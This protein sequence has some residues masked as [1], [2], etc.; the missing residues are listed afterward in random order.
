MILRVALFLLMALGLGGFGTIAWM[1]MQPPPPPP[2]SA[3]ADA[4]P[5]PPARANVRAA[6]RPLRAGTLVRP[7]DFAPR[8]MLASEVPPD[9]VPDT[10]TVRAQLGGGMLRR[11]LG[12]GDPFLRP[13]VMRPGDRGFLAAVLG[14]GTR[15][16]S[17]TVDGTLSAGGLIWPGDRVDLILTQTLDQQQG[18]AAAPPARR[19]MGETVMADLRVVAVDRHLTQGAMGDTTD[20]GIAGGGSRMVTVEVSREGAERIAVAERLGKLSLSIRAAED[21]DGG[22]IQEGARRPT[23]AGDVSPALNANTGTGQAEQ[24]TVNVFGGTADRKEYKF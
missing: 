15:A 23:W 1:G 3:Q 5:P 20:S 8:D 13:D 4:P 9:A 6:A 16:V 21:D 11:S 2:V 22:W 24:R 14:A 18:A 10:P 17:I 7:E 19:A 12:Q